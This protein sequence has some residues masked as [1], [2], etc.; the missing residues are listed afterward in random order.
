MV[1]IRRPVGLYSGLHSELRGAIYR[2][3][4]AAATTSTYTLP[5]KCRDIIAYSVLLRDLI[6]CEIFENDKTR[7]IPAASAGTILYEVVRG[8][9]FPSLQFSLMARQS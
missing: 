9:F 6:A 1:G 2:L 5:P 8:L 4:D 3:L 7:W